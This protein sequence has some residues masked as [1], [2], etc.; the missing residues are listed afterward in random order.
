MS[1]D[2]LFNSCVNQTL[3]NNP[4]GVIPFNSCGLSAIGFFI[5][6]LLVFLVLFIFSS[7]FRNFIFCGLGGDF[8]IYN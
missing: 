1:V 7:K 8:G 2:F 3:V 5:L 6:G 4:F